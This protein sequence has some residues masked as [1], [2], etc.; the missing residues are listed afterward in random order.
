MLKYSYDGF[1]F[2]DANDPYKR[3]LLTF[4]SNL[5]EETRKKHA[6][7]IAAAP[8]LLDFVIQY[9]YSEHGV[10]SPNHEAAPYMPEELKEM[11]RAAILKATGKEI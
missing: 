3:R 4:N 1:G 2:N 8:K 9:L 7:L 5:D 6:R 10:C 11:A